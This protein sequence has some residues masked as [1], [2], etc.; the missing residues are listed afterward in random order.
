[1]HFAEEIKNIKDFLFRFSFPVQ[2]PST[3]KPLIYIIC[4]YTIRIVQL[5]QIE[6][7]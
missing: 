5:E 4:T 2:P 1:M 7:G 3:V 6:Y